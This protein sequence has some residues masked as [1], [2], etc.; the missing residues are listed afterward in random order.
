MNSNRNIN[1]A[2]ILRGKELRKPISKAQ[3]AAKRFHRVTADLVARVC[4][5]PCH[6]SQKNPWLT[7]GVCSA[8]TY[9]TR[10]DAGCILQPSTPPHLHPSF[11]MHLSACDAMPRQN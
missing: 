4:S 2:E 8:K 5:D 10:L 7:V 11:T 3:D 1:L 6:F 9:L